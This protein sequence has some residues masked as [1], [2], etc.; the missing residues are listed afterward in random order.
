MDNNKTVKTS[1]L[2]H[3]FTLHLIG[4]LFCKDGL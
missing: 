4:G 3:W 1:P 2:N